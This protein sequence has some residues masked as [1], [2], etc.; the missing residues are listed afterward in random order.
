[1]TIKQIIAAIIAQEGGYVNNPNDRGGP[2]KYGITIASYKEYI[3]NRGNGCPPTA[4]QIK[5]VTKDLAEKIYFTLYYV[6][7]NIIS[8]PPL[9]QPI[10]LDMAVNHGRRGA[11]KIL[12]KTLNANGY[13]AGTADGL[14]GINTINAATKAVTEL[15]Q[16][17]INDL[18][19]WR[20][21]YYRQIIKNDP[22][23]AEFKNGWF[24]RA[25]SF[26]PAVA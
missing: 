15:G 8:L 11:V 9:I 3:G 7:P 22:T 5:A 10:M 4:A 1:M 26:R 21:N 25:E 13:N 19:D 24:A 16:N 18:V 17:F 20:L 14:I 12:Q 6:R 23:Q 2:T